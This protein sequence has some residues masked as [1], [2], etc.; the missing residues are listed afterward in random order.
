[1]PGRRPAFAVTVYED[2]GLRKA[3]VVL[4]DVCEICVGFAAFVA[5]S[6]YRSG[7]VVDGV[8]GVVPAAR[9]E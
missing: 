5:G 2:I 3:I 4:K 6:V 8:D 7:S 9:N 1:M